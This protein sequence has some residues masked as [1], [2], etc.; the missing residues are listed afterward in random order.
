[1]DPDS[2]SHTHTLNPS[3]PHSLPH[4]LTP[5]LLYLLASLTCRRLVTDPHAWI[6]T[7]IHSHTHTHTFPH[8]L[9]HSLPP[10][11]TP[12]LL[13]LLASLTCRRLVTDPHAWIK[14][15]IH[16]HTLTHTHTHTHT[17]S[18][19]HSLT[20][21]RTPSLLYLLA[22]L[23]CRRLV[24]DPHAWIQTAIRRTHSRGHVVQ[25]STRYCQ[26]RRLTNF[27]T[28]HCPKLNLCNAL[29]SGYVINGRFL[30]CVL[31]CV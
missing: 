23:T 14:T 19:T 25:L 17:H 1:M 3:L 28:C 30:H 20:H 12:S 4:S 15:A 7:A 22:S 24:T 16:T 18:L 2:H 9:T 11:L 27:F 8:S 21:S 31:V 6:Q 5:S 10:S 26:L 13:Y 29:R